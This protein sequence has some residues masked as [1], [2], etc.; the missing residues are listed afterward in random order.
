[1][2]LIN[3]EYQ[4]LLFLLLVLYLFLFREYVQQFHFVLLS[5]LFNKTL[6]V[7]EVIYLTLL[8]GI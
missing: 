1:M 7:E 2:N 8:A 6:I 5:L 3:N 4:G